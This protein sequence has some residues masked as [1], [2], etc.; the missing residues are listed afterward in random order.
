MKTRVSLKYFVTDCR[1]T[2]WLLTK[3]RVHQNETPHSRI[4]TRNSFERLK[5]PFRKTNTG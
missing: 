4:D 3:E 1:S 5:H 2:N